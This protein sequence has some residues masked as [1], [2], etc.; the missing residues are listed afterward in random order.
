[1]GYERRAGVRILPSGTSALLLE[2]GGVEEV[3]DWHVA[4]SEARLPGVV[5]LVPAA[6]T[7]LVV[8]SPARTTAAAHQGTAPVPTLDDL[9]SRLRELHPVR[10]RRPDN[11]E[12]DAAGERPEALEVPVRYDGEDLGE[13]A[14]LWGCDVAEVVRRH[15][16]EDWTVAFCGFAPGFGYLVADER[17]DGWDVP[18]RDMPRT[19]VP[20]GSVGL[21]GP[22]TG[23]YPRASPG[24]WQLV[25]RTTLELFDAR[26][27]PPALL[28]P[29]RR[30]RF[31]DVT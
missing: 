31:V 14:T 3:R 15:T 23:D 24:G 13:V 18:R 7:L 12:D 1:V 28:V 25:G 9:A 10:T 29:G 27:D 8:V 26:R 6:R 21:A 30:V 2:L 11:P 4:V 22:Y 17:G 16:A 20:A 5:D 19:S